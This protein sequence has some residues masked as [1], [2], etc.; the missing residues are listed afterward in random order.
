LAAHVAAE[1]RRRGAFTQAPE[2]VH[3]L[4]SGAWPCRAFGQILGRRFSVVLLVVVVRAPLADVS[5]QIED[6]LGRSAF[7]K[8]ADGFA[9]PEGRAEVGPCF[10]RLFVSPRIFA[11]A[12]P[13]VSVFPLG[14]RGQPFAG[15]LGVGAGLIVVC[16][17]DGKSGP[18][19]LWRHKL[20]VLIL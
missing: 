11:N 17:A 18:L 14:L 8:A 20:S 13:V 5:C 9:A 4:E 15:P 6:S 7:G 1:I 12:A 19:R 3:T 16:S 10:A 2:T